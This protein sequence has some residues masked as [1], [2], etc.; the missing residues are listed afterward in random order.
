MA[1]KRLSSEWRSSSLMSRLAV[2]ENGSVQ[3]PDGPPA[4][5]SEQKRGSLRFFVLGF[6]CALLFGA[7]ALAIL[8]IIS[9]ALARAR[10]SMPAGSS[11][12]EAVPGLDQVTN[13]RVTRASM[14]A[15]DGVHVESLRKNQ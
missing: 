14:S 2:L 10:T 13:Y 8:L 11:V 1:R 6:A 9:P 5:E 12:S 15:L 3:L 7:I 4:T